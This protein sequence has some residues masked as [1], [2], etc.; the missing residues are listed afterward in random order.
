MRRPPQCRDG[1]RVVL[2]EG[3]DGG[4]HRFDATAYLHAHVERGR[5]RGARDAWCKQGTGRSNA[6]EMPNHRGC[7]KKG[8]SLQR[9]LL[10]DQVRDLSSKCVVKLGAWRR[11]GGAQLNGKGQCAGGAG[12][13]RFFST[14]DSPR[15]SKPLVRRRVDVPSWP[16]MQHCFGEALCRGILAQA[17]HWRC[18]LDLAA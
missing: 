16:S 11:T 7:G 18:T 2:L 10:R 5:R 6:Q 17:L 12:F 14:F 9:L 1:P 15:A 8:R 4:A 13:S 3:R